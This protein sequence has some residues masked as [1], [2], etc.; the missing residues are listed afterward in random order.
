MNR[1]NDKERMFRDYADYAAFVG[2]MA[3]AQQKYQ[4]ASIGEMDWVEAT[5]KSLGVEFSIRRRGRPR[6]SAGIAT[7][8]RFGFQP[9]E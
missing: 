6:K 9:D 2:F 7:T 4:L 3:A 5:A 8:M 1:A